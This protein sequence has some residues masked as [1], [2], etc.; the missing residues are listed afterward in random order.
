MMYFGCYVLAGPFHRPEETRKKAKFLASACLLGGI[1][2]NVVSLWYVPLPSIGSSGVV[3]AFMGVVLVESIV[4][5]AMIG[6]EKTLRLRLWRWA[7]F[8]GGLIGFIALPSI[9]EPETFFVVAPFVNSICHM[10]S[11]VAGAVLTAV[12]EVFWTVKHGKAIRAELVEDFTPRP[13]SQESA[14]ASPEA[15]AQ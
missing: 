11:F 9:L 6:S 4:N 1:I 15:P 12:F 3:Y 14:E 13:N 8:N 5:V 10:T 7:G 2:A